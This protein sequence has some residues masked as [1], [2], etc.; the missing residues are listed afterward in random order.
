MGS[1]DD[2]G[3][4]REESGKGQLMRDIPVSIKKDPAL[5]EAAARRN[6]SNIMRLI[7]QPFGLCVL[8]AEM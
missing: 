8:A 3:R 6:P 4:A 7:E 5:C 2:R 1:Q